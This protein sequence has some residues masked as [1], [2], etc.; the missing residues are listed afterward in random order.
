LHPHK[1]SGLPKEGTLRGSLAIRV[2]VCIFDRQIHRSA[3]PASLRTATRPSLEAAT[4]KQYAYNKHGSGPQ[5]LCSTAVR[6][7]IIVKDG[8][9]D[10]RHHLGGLRGF[11]PGWRDLEVLGRAT[12]ASTA[13]FH[14]DDLF[15]H[16][17]VKWSPEDHWTAQLGAARGS[18]DPAGIPRNPLC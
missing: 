10:S 5:H 14:W 4:L 15:R 6:L 8:Y 18:R 16:Q 7:S 17:K 3:D 9:V 11:A 12:V 1:A 2:L 13:A